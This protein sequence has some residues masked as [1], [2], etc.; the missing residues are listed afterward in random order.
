MGKC[1]SIEP[2]GTED[3][4][5]L[6]PLGGSSSRLSTGCPQTDWER[7]R[8]EEGCPRGAG[9]EKRRGH[10]HGKG[11]KSTR[12]L[13]PMGSKKTK[14]KTK[15]ML[16]GEE[17]QILPHPSHRSRLTV[18]WKKKKDNTVYSLAGAT[19]PLGPDHWERGKT[20]QDL[21]CS[22]TESA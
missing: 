14:T 20:T 4:G 18:V 10:Y 13:L 3:T 12:M 2:R 8:R 7:V 6:H 9:V 17:Q 5:Y 22:D 11:R 21:R 1:E 15:N 16:L 19:N